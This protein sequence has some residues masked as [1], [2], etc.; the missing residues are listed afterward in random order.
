M[1]E[2]IRYVVR[3]KKDGLYYNGN[4][5]FPFENFENFEKAKVFKNIG[6]AK[7]ACKSLAIHK[8]CYHE[9]IDEYEIIEIIT[10]LTD[11]VIKYVLN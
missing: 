10:K 4:K 9:E 6:S 3:R 2:V 8:K 11:K 7:C 1:E 5:T